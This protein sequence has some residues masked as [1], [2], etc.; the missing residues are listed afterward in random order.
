LFLLIFDPS[1]G[2]HRRGRIAAIAAAAVPA[3]APFAGWGVEG[4]EREIWVDSLFLVLAV[5]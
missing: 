5:E 2:T 1:W 4:R 3:E